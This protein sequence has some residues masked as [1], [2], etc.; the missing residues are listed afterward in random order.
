MK[1]YTIIVFIVFFYLSSYAQ[2]KL[3][4]R[5]EPYFFISKNVVS[6]V[7]SYKSEKSFNPQPVSIYA[8]Y[9]YFLDNE[10]IVNPKLGYL[11]SSDNSEDFFDG[12]EMG[13][14][15]HYK[16]WKELYLSS[17]IMMHYNNYNVYPQIIIESGWIPFLVV[18]SGINIT[19][20][21]NIELQYLIALKKQYGLINSENTR[22]VLG[23]LKLSFGFEW[24][25]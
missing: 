22:K 14:L 15:L 16:T 2:S 20:V 12:W 7:L 10:F 4:W 1:K 19:N 5:Y 23:E 8:S 6:G 3:G 11:I 24:E 13:L 25:L 21:F 17:G 9:K 18:G